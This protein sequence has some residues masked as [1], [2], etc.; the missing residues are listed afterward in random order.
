MAAARHENELYPLLEWLERLKI[1]SEV[2]K[3]IYLNHAPKKF[4]EE[5]RNGYILSKLAVAAD[6]SGS[7]TYWDAVCTSPNT[8]YGLYSCLKYWLSHV[9]TPILLSAISNLIN[10]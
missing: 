9:G 4:F 3:H 2:D 6:C 8:R 1:V 10:Y 5:V 7:M